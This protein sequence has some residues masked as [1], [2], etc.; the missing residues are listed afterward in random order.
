MFIK[1]LIKNEQ[2]Y[3]EFV[4]P[5][6]DWSNDPNR[7]LWREED[8]PKLKPFFDMQNRHEEWTQEVKE[9]FDFYKKCSEE[10]G[11]KNKELRDAV[12]RISADDLLEAFGYELPEY[13][14]EEDYYTTKPPFDKD[15]DATFPFVVIGDIHCG[16]DRA[17]DI[18]ILSVYMVSLKDF[19][20]VS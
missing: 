5:F 2:E 20:N 17:G 1:Q 18:T 14:D 12:S 11:D 10:Y 16:W 8:L 19:E 6:I 3:W 7:S 9:S 13:D 15:F 4:W